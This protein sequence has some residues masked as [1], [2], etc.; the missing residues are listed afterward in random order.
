M[1]NYLEQE[2]IN[3]NMNKKPDY[4]KFLEKVKKE[5]KMAITRAQNIKKKYQEKKDEKLACH[6]TSIFNSTNDDEE[7]AQRLQEFY[8][9]NN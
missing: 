6:L 1:N 7:L 3:K 4:Q 8:Y 5:E 9:N 2:S